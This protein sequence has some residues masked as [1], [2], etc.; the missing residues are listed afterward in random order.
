M[1][2]E[3]VPATPSRPLVEIENAKICSVRRS[4]LQS[5]TETNK[6]ASA[7]PADRF[8]LTRPMDCLSFP[9]AWAGDASPFLFDK[10]QNGLDD[11][12][13]HSHMSKYSTAPT[14]A[15]R[16]ASARRPTNQHCRSLVACICSDFETRS[17]LQC[18]HRQWVYSP[19]ISLS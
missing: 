8:L 13:R 18:R 2:E 9:F 15:Q 19:P 4:F 6:Q 11:A 16:I 14:Q 1:S 3:W 5:A 7:R 10:P 12:N 17:I